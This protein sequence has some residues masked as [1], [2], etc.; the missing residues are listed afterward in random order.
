MKIHLFFI[1]NYFNYH[2][3]FIMENKINAG[4]NNVL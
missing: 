4:L 2:K 1:A 3:F